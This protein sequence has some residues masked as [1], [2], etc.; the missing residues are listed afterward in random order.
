MFKFIQETA[1]KI[2]STAGAES[3]ILFYV[4]AI[5][6]MVSVAYLIVFATLNIIVLIYEAVEKN[7]ADKI[8]KI[9]AEKW[10]DEHPVH[11]PLEIIERGFDEIEYLKVY[12]VNGEKPVFDKDKN[13]VFLPVGTVILR[14][15]RTESEYALRIKERG[16]MGRGSTIIDSVKRINF[17]IKM[18]KKMFGLIPPEDPN[19][20]LK[21]GIAIELSVKT[22][23][24]YQAKVDPYD[25]EIHIIVIKDDK[26][27]VLEFAADKDIST[28]FE[29]DRR[30]RYEKTYGDGKN[31]D[32]SGEE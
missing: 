5:V 16:R 9:R 22:D 18:F 32:N 12:S 21:L 31:T 15:G 1:Q 14:I 26:P 25:N 3:A 30:E 2:T 24:Q 10:L 23:C 8:E 6:F 7:K 28:P 20:E 27:T 11:V 19:K 4:M 13:N 29:K 17:L